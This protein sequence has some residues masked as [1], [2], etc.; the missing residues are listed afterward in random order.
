MARSSPTLSDRSVGEVG[1]PTLKGVGAVV[2]GFYESIC[3]Y[4]AK[5]QSKSY[6]IGST[7]NIKK[8]LYQHNHGQVE[9]TKNKRSYKLVFHQEFSNIKI[10]NKI[11]HKIKKWKRRD[12]I[13]KIIKDGKIISSARSS[14]DRAKGF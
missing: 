3:L 14:V 9:S 2:R 6:Y 5:S 1:A 10:A 8:R 4:S 11:E 12:F 7:L 13:E